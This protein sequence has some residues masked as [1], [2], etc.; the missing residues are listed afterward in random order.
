MTPEFLIAAL[1][2][3]RL[4]VTGV[5]YTIAIG[6]ARGWAASLVA[7]NRPAVH[8]NSTLKVV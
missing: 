1:I 7:A 5:L 6:I 2:V 4:S 3:F 8:A